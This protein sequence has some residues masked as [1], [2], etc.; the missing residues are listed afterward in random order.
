LHTGVRAFAFLGSL[1]SAVVTPR[2][3]NVGRGNIHDVGWKFL[4]SIE[5]PISFLVYLM[6]SHPSPAAI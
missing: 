1:I 6:G 2:V 3:A 4:V 5:I